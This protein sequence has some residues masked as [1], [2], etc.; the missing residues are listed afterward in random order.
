MINEKEVSKY[1]SEQVIRRADE[2]Q[3]PL[4]YVAYYSECNDYTFR[5]YMKGVRL[6]RI[7]TL[8]M[9]A[10]LFECSVNELLDY[11]P[12]DVPVRNRI[13]DSGMD[14]KGVFEHV[15]CKIKHMMCEQNMYLSDLAYYSYMPEVQLQ[16]S[17]IHSSE[18]GT[19]DLLN[20]CAALS[21][22]PS[23]LLGY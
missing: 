4:W 19:K 13:F 15:A 12:Y 16:Y 6:P 23:D 17:L 3:I 22:T 5:N 7:T 21:C 18:I 14:S 8:I 10:E 2:M 1:F 9:V 11:E 20:I